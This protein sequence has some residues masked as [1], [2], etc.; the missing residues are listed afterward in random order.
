MADGFEA[1]LLA[2]LSREAKKEAI[3][4]YGPA[5]DEHPA[6]QRH[7]AETGPLLS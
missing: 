1:V 4:T 5:F 3:A 2:G 6:W 7:G